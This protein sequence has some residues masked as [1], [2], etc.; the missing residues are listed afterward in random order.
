MS[1]GQSTAGALRLQ[2][3]QELHSQRPVACLDFLLRHSLV[4]MIASPFGM[5]QFCGLGASE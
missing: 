1:Q 3:P 4:I 2:R 5:S